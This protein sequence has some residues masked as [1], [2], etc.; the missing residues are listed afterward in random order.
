MHLCWAPQAGL[1]SHYGIQKHP[2][3]QKLS[4]IYS[5]RTL[6]RQESLTRGFNDI[7]HAPHSRYT[8]IDRADIEANPN[9]TILADS[10]LAGPYIIQD[11]RHGKIFITGHPEYSRATLAHEYFRDVKKGINPAIPRRYFAE[12]DPEQEPIFQWKAHAYLLF[13][14]WLNYEVYQETPYDLN[15]INYTQQK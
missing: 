1:Y 3:P 5:H 13:S 12:D 10:E 7:F 8:G 11:K 6:Y 15:L 4:G 2:L 14:N 9:L